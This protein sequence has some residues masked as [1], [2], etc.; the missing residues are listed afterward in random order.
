MY[1]GNATTE[2]KVATKL[3]QPKGYKI[4]IGVPEISDKTEGGVLM[5]DG[6]KASE[7]TLLLLVLLWS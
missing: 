6:I 3:P 1:T 2:E 4:L 7:E 5:P